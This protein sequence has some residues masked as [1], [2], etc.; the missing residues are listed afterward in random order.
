MTL[1]RRLTQF[2]GLA[3][4]VIGVAAAVAPESSAGRA[5]RRL[6]DRL[7]RDV[8]YAAG[9][10]PG[11]L[12]R[13]SGR[14]PDPDAPDDVLADRV[15]SA[16]GPLEKRLDLPRIHVMVDDHVAILH[17]DVPDD[18]DAGAIQHAVLRVSGVTGV[19]S[20]LHLGLIPGDTRPSE[21]AA[22]TPPPSDAWRALMETARDAGA[23][24]APVAAVHAVLCGLMDRLPE[25]ERAQV[26]AHLPADVRALVGPER[27]AGE[28]AP[29]L[30]TLA[31]FVAAVTAVG[32][33]DARR[34]EA[35]TRAVLAT[36]RGLVQEEA[37]DVAAVLPGELRELWETEPA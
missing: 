5:V 34:A 14:R 7:S 11:L 30:K 10:A 29:R 20:H 3:A 2:A 33:I 9:A 36:L 4:G 37:H 25:G 6:A 27:P 15:R 13:L 16:I 1:T 22:V 28:R 21:G 19:V 8:R 24:D 26:L 18:D 17:G 32:G 12:Y 31:Q 23:G 35:I